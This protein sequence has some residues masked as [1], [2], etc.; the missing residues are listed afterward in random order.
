MKSFTNVSLVKVT[1]NRSHF[2]KHGLHLN[3]TGKEL[4]AKQIAEQIDQI[5]NTSTKTEPPLP[6]LWKQ[7]KSDEEISVVEEKAPV[8]TN[9]VIRRSSSRNKKV[10]VTRTTDFLWETLM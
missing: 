1:T 3:S 2:T 9:K 5:M 6:L 10:P 8:T 7:E 4:I